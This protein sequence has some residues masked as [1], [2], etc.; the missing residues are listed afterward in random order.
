MPQKPLAL[1]QSQLTRAR[2]A[3]Y[4]RKPSL[5]LK[6]AADA[7]KFVEAVGFCYLWP[8]AGVDMPSLWAAVAG[9]RPVADEHDDPGH[10]TWGWKDQSLDNDCRQTR[11]G[12]Y[13]LAAVRR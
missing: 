12:V 9:D 10:V 8:I 2:D 1:S 13:R 5:R 6:S 7:V 11:G 4:R 3:R